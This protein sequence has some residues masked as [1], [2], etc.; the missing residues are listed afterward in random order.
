MELLKEIPHPSAEQLFVYIQIYSI[1]H[2][3]LYG[4]HI[5]RTEESK[6]RRKMIKRHVRYHNGRFSHCKC[7]IDPG[8]GL[9]SP[10]H[11]DQASVHPQYLL[12]P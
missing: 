2:L 9:S 6:L 10:H 5:L 1:M 7:S 12:E 8:I 11:S 3:I 4:V